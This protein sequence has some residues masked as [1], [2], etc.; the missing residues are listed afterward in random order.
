VTTWGRSAELRSVLGRS[1]VPRIAVV[2]GGIAGLAAAHRLVELGAARRTPVEPILIEALD[3]LGGTIATEYADGYLIEGGPDAFLTEKPWA[4]DLCGRLGLGD[5]LILTQPGR[6][7]TLVLRGHRLLPLPDGFQL[8]APSRLIPLWRS[9][10]LSWRG[11]LRA[12]TDLL[13]PRRRSQDDESVGGFVVRRFGREVLER[14]VQ[15]LVT[16]IYAADPSAV[17]LRATMP[18][19]AEMERAEGSVIRALRRS[20]SRREVHNAS[21]P[22]WSLFAA[23]AGGMQELVVG[24]AERL[25]ASSVKLRRRVTSLARAVGT[26]SWRVNLADGATLLVDGVILAVPGPRAAR[27]LSGLDG[28]LSDQLA[29]IRYHSSAVVTLGYERSAVRHRLDAFGFVV[30]RVEGRP[31]LACSFSSLKF[32]GRAPDGSVLLRVFVGGEGAAAVLARDDVDL[33]GVTQ[34]HL[35]EILGISSPPGV[36]RVHRH[37]GAMPQYDV[38]HLEHVEAIRDRVARHPGLAVCGNALTG[39]GIPD[40]IHSGE[41][42][43]E[44]VLE[45]TSGLIRPPS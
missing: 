37:V 43:A 34:Q 13:L 42:A 12:T 30:P 25:P 23:P 41:Q 11:K 17:S 33:A 16:A 32:A 18:R 3:R 19:F 9:P 27:L 38:G 5:R 1:E 2:G 14:M 40:C 7:R 24:L 21:G 10:V 39:V 44:Q 8:L 22:R 29:A 20:A 15:P 31:I 36:V 4:V 45:S 28:A 6:R 26:R 35:R